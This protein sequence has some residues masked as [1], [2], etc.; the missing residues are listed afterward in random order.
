MLWW[1][2]S[3]WI[4]LCGRPT[5][6]DACE[7]QWSRARRNNCWRRFSHQ[8]RKWHN[9]FWNRGPNLCQ[10]TEWLLFYL[11]FTELI[12]KIYFFIHFIKHFSLG[13]ILNG[14][15]AQVICWILFGQD[16]QI[17]DGV[18]I[19]AAQESFA[20]WH[21]ANDLRGAVD[22]YAFCFRFI[23]AHRVVEGA[24]FCFLLLSILCFEII[25]GKR[26]KNLIYSKL[27]VNRNV[28]DW[29]Q[30]YFMFISF[31]IK[32]LLLSFCSLSMMLKSMYIYV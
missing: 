12:F 1:K 23:G 7:N 9:L 6:P 31:Y 28:L 15:N 27:F 10:Q 30:N 8:N 20:S 3:F 21:D 25:V 2:P 16:G 19:G 4:R 18:L 24:C 11:F 14:N 26:K 22:Q 32:F 29:N 13:Y 5:R 17:F